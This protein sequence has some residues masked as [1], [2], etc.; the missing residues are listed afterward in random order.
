MRL[1]ELVIDEYLVGELFE[2]C[3]ERQQ[4]GRNHSLVAEVGVVFAIELEE[5]VAF[6]VE[7]FGVEILD[8]RVLEARLLVLLL[9]PVVGIV[10][11]VL[12]REQ[13]VAGLIILHAINYYIFPQSIHH[14]PH[15]N[16][17]FKIQV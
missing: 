7:V 4:F 5:A 3:A 14:L 16:R 13:L 6:G 11:G 2:F 15:L 8:P 17:V 12:R 9:L 10:E 1:F